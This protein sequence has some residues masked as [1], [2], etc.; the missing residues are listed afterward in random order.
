MSCSR[1]KKRTVGLGPGLQLLGP[2]IDFRCSEERRQSGSR[3][4]DYL[5]K[6]AV[7][8]PALKTEDSP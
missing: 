3:Y 6:V 1:S 7:E 8:T 4:L 5:N 2:S